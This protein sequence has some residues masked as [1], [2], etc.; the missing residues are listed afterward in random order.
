MKRLNIVVDKDLLEK[1]MQVSGER[2]YAGA[3][4]KAMKELVRVSDLK[5]AIEAMRAKKDFFYPG[6]FEQIRPNSWYA[7]E[8]KAEAERSSKPSN[9]ATRGRR[10]R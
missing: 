10:T 2:T 6:Y 9:K 7:L 4:T 8:K 1:T 5:S 3:I